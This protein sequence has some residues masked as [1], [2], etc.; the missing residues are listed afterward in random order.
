MERGGH[1]GIQCEFVKL[2]LG[3]KGLDCLRVGA[4]VA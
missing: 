2:N 1:T 3:E 4:I